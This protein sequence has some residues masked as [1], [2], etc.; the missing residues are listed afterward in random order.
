MNPRI[1]ST[2]SFIQKTIQPLH[3]QHFSLLKKGASHTQS[4]PETYL[5]WFLTLGPTQSGKTTLL[6]QSELQLVSP[7]QHSTDTFASTNCQ[8]WISEHSAFLDIPG[9]FLHIDSENKSPAWISLLNLI[10]K[11]CRQSPLKGILLVIN[12]YDVIKETIDLP[13]LKTQLSSL[14]QKIKTTPP[15]YLVFTQCDRIAGFNEFF[16]DLGPRE[17]NNYWGFSLQS[18]QSHSSLVDTF[19]QE[20]TQFIKRLNQRVIWRLHHEHN[21]EAKFF[22]KDF[23]LQLEN[24]KTAFEKIVTH[25]T[26]HTPITGLYFCSG[27]QKGDQLDTL[28]KTSHL[29]RTFEHKALLPSTQV[30]RPYFVHEL[31]NEI[32]LQDEPVIQTKHVKTKT[33]PTG[34]FLLL[35]PPVLA[36]LFWAQ[37][38]QL[39][40]NQFNLATHTYQ[41]FQAIIKNETLSPSQLLLA[42]DKLKN[43]LTYLDRFQPSW[44]MSQNQH[45]KHHWQQ[46]LQAAYSTTLQSRLLPQL[47]EQ[48]EQKL[49]AST[50][51]QPEQTYSLL[52]TY[53][54]LFEPA[55]T[56]INHLKQALS[57]QNILSTLSLQEKEDYALFLAEAIQS[58]HP[59]LSIN[60]NLVH[61]AR[62][63]LDDMPYP[64]LAYALVKNTLPTQPLPLLS[65]KNFIQAFHFSD[66]KYESQ[67]QTLS[68]LYTAD[69]FSEIYNTLIPTVSQDVSKG[70]WILGKKDQGTLSKEEMHEL[71]QDV[72]DFYLSDYVNT[73]KKFIDTI[74]LNGFSNFNESQRLLSALCGPPSALEEL[75]QTIANN[76]SLSVLIKKMNDPHNNRNFTELL[77]KENIETLNQAALNTTLTHTTLVAL[78]NLQHDI[79]YISTQTKQNEAAL[80]IAQQ[81][82][83]NPQTNPITQL[84]QLSGS[85]PA[86][87]KGWLE[88]IAY[89]N[90]KLLLTASYAEISQTW[91]HTVSL[92]YKN[93]L[94]QRYPLSKQ[95]P[96]DA[97]TEDFKQFFSP[98]GLLASFFNHYLK[99]FVDT[100]KPR[101]KILKLA[102]LGLPISDAALEQ[103]ERASIISRMYFPQANDQMTLNF[104]LEPLALMPSLKY[105]AIRD[106]SGKEIVDAPTQENKPSTWSWPSDNKGGEISIELVSNEGQ[107]PALLSQKGEWAWFRLFDRAHLQQTNDPKRFELIF[108][109]NGN[110]AKYALV[111]STAINPFIPGIIEQFKCP[112]E[113]S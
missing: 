59:G 110:A 15:L 71:I 47:V 31:L 49:L 75:L 89:G 55:H 37:N 64:L 26:E 100:D 65:E 90:W 61:R 12:I 76:T 82:I 88:T 17:R 22:I 21:N 108:D 48:L 51:T 54:M 10:K 72:N 91:Q 74:Q 20:Y 103:L 43:S 19:N 96:F 104:Q 98:Q 25:L 40:K 62:Q 5:P 2:I 42:L 70:N 36:C 3:L 28:I 106:N 113:L 67:K 6:S 9:H 92:Y 111:A 1:Q 78:N 109:A 13:T 57:Q 73:W 97:K 45:L 8:W 33:L 105:V 41:D 7:T 77:A 80:K 112:D 83:Q 16:S 99:P 23:P 4:A 52:K 50:K 81:Y 39:Q 56:D 29:A 93:N 18:E 84:L 94:N 14:F 53:L 30:L 24:L 68:L 58:P 32:I 46:T 11:R 69:Y 107:N 79:Q 35:A 87:I 44:L 38:H 101:W 27:T 86:P 34:Y 85:Y 102:G 66:S 60:Q 95:T 63:S